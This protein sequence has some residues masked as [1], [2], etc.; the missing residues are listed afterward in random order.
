M[1]LFY[2]LPPCAQSWLIPNEHGLAKWV[3]TQNGTL[4]LLITLEPLRELQT[5]LKASL[6][7]IVSNN[8]LAVSHIKDPNHDSN[9]Q[10]DYRQS[11]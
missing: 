11:L 6:I 7:P 8:R 2:N 10:T 3:E 1:Q 9:I 4:R 5:F